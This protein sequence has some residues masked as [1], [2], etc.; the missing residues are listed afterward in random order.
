MGTLAAYANTRIDP[1][2]PEE[3]YVLTREGGLPDYTRLYEINPLVERWARESFTF[4][5]DAA[6][7]GADV[8]VFEGDARIVLERQL[9]R[10][11]GQRFDLLAVD[12]FNSDAIPIHLL[13]RE[14]FQTY[15]GH[16]NEDGILALHVTNRFVDLIPVVARLAEVTGLSAI[17]IENDG[18]DSRKV[19]SADWILLTNNL[20]FLDIEAVHQDEKAMP[21]PGPLWTDDFSSVFE[22][23]E[24]DD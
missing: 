4:L 1:D 5:E 8:D 11:E 2:R 21:E 22:V 6:S 10:G 18:S 17:Y 16:L 7:R 23:V 3:S 19:S 13:T 15:L 20:A 9:E 24:F 12:A 14:S